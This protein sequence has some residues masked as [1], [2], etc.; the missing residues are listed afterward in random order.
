MPDRTISAAGG[1]RN[2][3]DTATWDEGIVPTSADNVVVR[4]GGD[5]GNVN[6]TAAAAALSL[7]FT[8]GD[9]NGTFTINSG[10]TLTVSGNVTLNSSGTCT[11]I[12]GVG[13]GTLAINTGGTSLTSNGKTIASRFTY[14][15]ASGTLTL[16]D[17][18]TVTGLLNFSGASAPF[19]AGTGRTITASGGVNTANRCGVGSGCT[20]KITGGVCTSSVS[21]SSYGISGSGTVRFEGNITMTSLFVRTAVVD[22]IS[23]TWGSGTLHIGGTQ[24]INGSPPIDNLAVRTGA[25]TLTLTAP[26]TITGTLTIVDVNCTIL[27][28]QPITVPNIVISATRSLTYTAASLSLLTLHMGQGA[29]LTFGAG[30]TLTVSTLFTVGGFDTTQ[31]IQ[32]NTPGTPFTLA[33]A[34]A[35]ARSAFTTYT[36]VNV[37]GQTLVNVFGGTLTRTT[38][39]NTK[40]TNES[41]VDSDPG[42]ANAVY[43]TGYT[44]N[45]AALTGT[46]VPKMSS[47]GF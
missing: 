15:P 29:G 25:S 9:Y 11:G 8:A 47:G 32:S 34:G 41:I 12:I 40:P 38:G 19:F 4:A 20:L 39:I 21:G 33:L 42:I 36:D 46:F 7:N 14:N 45:G 37:T 18:A 13:T 28:G 5:S 30:Y 24:T 35:T 27:G 23:G 43:D 22:Y 6:V 26:L 2:W 3:N 10:I 17:D 31:N 1:T 44:I 16:V